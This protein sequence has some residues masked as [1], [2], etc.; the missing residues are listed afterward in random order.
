M[1]RAAKEH[2]VNKPGYVF[3][4]FTMLA[5]DDRQL[6]H[7]PFRQRKPGQCALSPVECQRL[8]G[9]KTHAHPESHEIDD[10]VETIQLHHWLDIETLSSQP[11]PKL[12][13]RVHFLLR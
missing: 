4:R 9:H 6:S 5:D 13:A 11:T 7:K 8:N 1:H 3:R 10:E 2:V 12:L